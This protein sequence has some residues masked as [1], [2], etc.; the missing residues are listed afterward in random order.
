M[1]RY[2]FERL[3][4]QDAGFLWAEIEGNC[5]RGEFYD[6]QAQLDFAHQICK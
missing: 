4:A 1:A 2:G 3:S 5:F 6:A